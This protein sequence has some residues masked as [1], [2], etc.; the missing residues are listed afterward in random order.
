[1][2]EYQAEID[3]SLCPTEGYDGLPPCILAVTTPGPRRYLAVV[4]LQILQRYY[5]EVTA[6]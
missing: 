6:W 4:P 2:T 3:L 5:G 1:M